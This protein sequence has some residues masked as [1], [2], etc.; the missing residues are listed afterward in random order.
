MNP[1]ILYMYAQ[2]KESIHWSKG[3]HQLDEEINFATIFRFHTT[4]FEFCE[5]R[6][7]GGEGR[8]HAQDPSALWPSS[9]YS[10]L[11]TSDPIPSISENVNI[12]LNWKKSLDHETRIFT[13]CNMWRSKHNSDG[14]RYSL[15]DYPTTKLGKREPEIPANPMQQWNS[16][17][18]LK[19]DMRV[20]LHMHRIRGICPWRYVRFW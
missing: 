13:F 18:K 2:L 20:E 6:R 16:K 1:W 7:G 19:I 17:Q 5:E 9:L 15:C 3:H 12:Y 4:Y 14:K 8:R 11:L 10:E